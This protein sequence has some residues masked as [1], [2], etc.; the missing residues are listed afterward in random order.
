[1]MNAGVS[2]SLEH[3][4]YPADL[5]EQ[6]PLCGRTICVHQRSSAIG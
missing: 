2:G 1:M 5:F 6:C 3:L 4:A